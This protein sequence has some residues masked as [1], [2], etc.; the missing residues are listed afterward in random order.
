MSDK[1]STDWWMWQMYRQIA[2]LINNPTDANEAQLKALIAEY[3]NFHKE[4]VISKRAS[5]RTCA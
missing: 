3:R 1:F 4:H 2:G 5:E